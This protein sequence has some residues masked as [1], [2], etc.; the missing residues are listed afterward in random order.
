MESERRAPALREQIATY[1]KEKARQQTML[2]NVK[3]AI[4]RG[5]S[6][7]TTIDSIMINLSNLYNQYFHQSDYDNLSGEKTEKFATQLSNIGNNIVTAYNDG[8][9]VASINVQSALEELKVK[10][11]N[12]EQSIKNIDT[13]IRSLN[14]QLESLGSG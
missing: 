4:S 13:M 8:F 6:L 1:E 7:K 14:E 11:N 12:F 9:K 3:R 5:E 2:D 10:K